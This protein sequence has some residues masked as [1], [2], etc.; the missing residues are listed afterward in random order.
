MGVTLLILTSLFVRPFVGKIGQKVFDVL[1]TI[2]VCN[3]PRP[4]D[5]GAPRLP[6]SGST[7]SDAER[8]RQIALR[9][10]NTRIKLTEPTKSSPD[11]A[12]VVI[13]ESTG[14]TP[15]PDSTSTA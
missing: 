13:T 9:D 3:K 6:L 15:A 12:V 8:R 14:S 11:D 2:H 4:I 5:L 10:L 7:A 1:V